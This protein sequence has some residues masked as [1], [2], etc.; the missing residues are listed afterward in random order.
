MATIL[1]NTEK[2]LV[3]N[4]VKKQGFKCKASKKRIREWYVNEYTGS[5]GYEDNEIYFNGQ[6]LYI[7]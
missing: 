4:A 7:A 1:N 2:N 5:F 3:K 6:Y